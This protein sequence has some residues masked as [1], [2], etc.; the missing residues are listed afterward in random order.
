M[1][2][3]S[4]A[5]HLYLYL[6]RYLYLSEVEEQHARFCL[7]MRQLF[8]AHKKDYT[9]YVRRLWGLGGGSRLA[10]CSSRDG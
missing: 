8:D 4:L 7:A 2:R 5:L 3:F 9:Y 10:G 6:Y 1:Y